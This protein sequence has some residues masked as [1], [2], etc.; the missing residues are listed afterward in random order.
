MTKT[1]YYLSISF[2][3]AKVFRASIGVSSFKFILSNSCVIS[4]YFMLN[5]SNCP[6]TCFLSSFYSLILT[7]PFSKERS[8]LLA[9]VTTFPGTPASFAT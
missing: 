9:L 4:S 6:A 3:L 1:Q 2:N 8:I 5:K 7:P